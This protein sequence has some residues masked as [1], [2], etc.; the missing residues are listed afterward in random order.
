MRRLSIPLLLLACAQPE[1]P[2]ASPA[3]ARIDGVTI[4]RAE[5]S[6]ALLE[7]QGEAY[8]Q[9]YVEAQLIERAAKAAG[10]VVADA[11]VEA[12]VQQQID[13]AVKTRFAGKIE[14]FRAQLKRFGMTEEAWRRGRVA[15]RRA[16]LQ[17][18]RLVEK[19]TFEDRVKLLFEQRYGKGGV[20]RA[21][22]HVLVA[23]SLASSRFYTRKDY[24]AEKDRVMTDARR[25]ADAIR[26][27]LV[28]GAQM[29]AQAAEHSD[30]FSAKQGGRLYANWSG[31]FGK[32]FDDA[33]KR[34]EVGQVSPVVEG[35]RGYHVAQVV[36]VRKGARYH[37]RH[38]LVKAKGEG[39]IEAALEKANA[40]R[41]R[42][43]A[44]E[45]FAEVAK[46]SSDDPVTRPK[47]GDLGRFSAGRL[48]ADADAVLETMPLKV[49]SKPL[50]V[51]EGYQI[52]ELTKREFMPAQDRKLVSH[53]LVSTEYVKVKARR[54]GAELEQ[55][56]EAK[57]KTLLTRAK[58]EG[59]DFA[60]LARDES[61]D[62]LTRRNGGALPR[63]A[64]RYGKAIAEA[65]GTMKSGE[66]R[67]VRSKLGFHVL[68]LDSVATSDFEK[69]RAELEKEA[70]KQP[71]SEEKVREFVKALREKAKVERL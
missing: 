34:L 28:E 60:K 12:A 66:I 13:D 6:D 15:E 46:A 21:A 70:G 53:V 26:R 33:V 16:Y 36:G 18:E 51:G 38:I 10:V 56:A 14:G 41:G 40:L 32:A 55:R 11:E 59:A 62:E 47:G 43:E 37:G 49:V 42:I 2:P 8:F 30:D 71:I 45:D 69:V 22:R 54:I 17:A 50:K 4:T 58:A 57:A 7:A 20:Q 65:L 63:H 23:T 35:R 52:V 67:L 3:F 5:F 27:A 61:E 44:G 24:E 1:P 29:S 39:G 68:K 64:T 9:R 31:R 19:Q 25:K 48:G